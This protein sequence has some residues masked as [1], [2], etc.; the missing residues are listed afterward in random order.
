MNIKTMRP[1]VNALPALLDEDAEMRRIGS[2]A[3]RVSMENQIHSIDENL[4]KI[5][6]LEME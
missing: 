1:R 3:E 5:F 6:G 2:I 4:S